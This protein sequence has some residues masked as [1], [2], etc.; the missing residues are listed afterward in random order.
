[1]LEALGLQRRPRDV[2]TLGQILR[3]NGNGVHP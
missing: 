1:L 2:T 3:G